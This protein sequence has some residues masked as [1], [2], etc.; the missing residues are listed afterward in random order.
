LK[1]A[2]SRTTRGIIYTLFE[3]LNQ[4]GKVVMWVKAMNMLEARER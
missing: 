4:R 1:T 2:T 3:V